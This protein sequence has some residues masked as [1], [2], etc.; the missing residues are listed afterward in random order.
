MLDGIRFEHRWCVRIDTTAKHQQASWLKKMRAE[1]DQRRQSAWRRIVQHMFRRD[2][3]DSNPEA[4]YQM[5]E[6]DQ[7]RV[8][9]QLGDQGFSPITMNVHVWHED[10]EIAKQRALDVE[11]MLKDL[12][13]SAEIA[14]IS[15]VLAP[16]ADIPGNDP[17]PREVPALFAQITRISPVTGTS[18]GAEMDGKWDGPALTLGYSGAGVPVR[19]AWHAPGEKLGNTAVIG[20]SRGGKSALIAKLVAASLKYPASVALVFDIGRSFLPTCLCLGGNWHELSQN[21]A[22][23]QPLRHIDQPEAWLTAFEWLCRA[24]AHQ[25]IQRNHETD[26]ALTTALRLTALLPHEK[27]TMSELVKRIGA[28]IQVHDAMLAFTKQ[29]HWGDTFDG[30]VESYG[31]SRVVGI[32]VG[33][34][35]RSDALPLIV[36]AIFDA[37]RFERLQGRSLRGGVRRVPRADQ[38]ARLP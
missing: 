34:I 26:H 32:E 28:S 13:F 14:T 27:R 37:I 6:A 4:R 12:G 11:L 25:G 15:A 18:R 17:Q 33:G 2:E 38:A 36:S 8:D 31:N 20:Q 1:Y 19:L 3:P 35:R 22:C 23:V 16:L 29:G 10:E 21:T 24:L 9:V 30:V 7:L 5:D